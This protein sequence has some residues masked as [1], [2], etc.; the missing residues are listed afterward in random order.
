MTT[1][2]RYWYPEIVTALFVLLF[3]Y[4]ALSKLQDYTG[5][6]RAMLHSPVIAS[7]ARELAI[8]IPVIE[9]GIVA[10][11]IVPATR[12]VG[13]I[14]STVIMALFSAYIAYMLVTSSELPCT[15][16]G[17]LEHLS[18]AAHLAI[19]IFFFLLGIFSVLISNKNFI[20]INRRSRTPV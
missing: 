18:W 17:I 5:F 10:L 15:C 11:L 16:G 12:M 20:M 13:L 1:K 19:N 4:T 8:I 2:L 7:F 3:L 6:A 14:A 9:I